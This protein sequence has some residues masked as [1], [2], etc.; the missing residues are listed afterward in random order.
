MIC[1]LNKSTCSAKYT[2]TILNIRTRSQK[3]SMYM[4]NN[5]NEENDKIQIS[6]NYSHFT[7]KEYLPVSNYF[8]N[9]FW[10]YTKLKFLMII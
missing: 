1:I 8:R 5:N 3:V 9:K 2:K 10:R 7:G 6:Y 4:L